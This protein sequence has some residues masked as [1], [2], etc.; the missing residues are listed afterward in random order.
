MLFS[1]RYWLIQA[2]ISLLV[3]YAATQCCAKWLQQVDIDMRLD[4]ITSRVLRFAKIWCTPGIDLQIRGLRQRC[5]GCRMRGPAQA[6]AGSKAAS[7]AICGS[8]S[9]EK[10]V[11]T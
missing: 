9:V 3:A 6:A 11:Q 8:L 4:G 5:C 7:R 1:S 10:Q 2:H